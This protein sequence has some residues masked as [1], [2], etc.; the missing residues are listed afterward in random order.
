VPGTL[1]WKEF[2]SKRDNV[3]SAKSWPEFL[4]EL[5]QGKVVDLIK[6]K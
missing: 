6:R 1:K 5:A 3:N 4:R 2:A